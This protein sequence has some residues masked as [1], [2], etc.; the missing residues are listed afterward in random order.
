MSKG[1]KEFQPVS[2]WFLVPVVFF[3]WV[4]LNEI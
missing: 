4:V 2:L 3:V 1:K